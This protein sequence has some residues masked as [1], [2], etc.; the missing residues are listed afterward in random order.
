[1]GVGFYKFSK[2]EAER[3]AQQRQ[4]EQLRIEASVITS[5]KISCV[6]NHEMMTIML[7]RLNKNV[8][9]INRSRRNT[10]KNWQ[11]VQK[12]YVA[13][14]PG[15]RARWRQTSKYQWILLQRMLSTILFLVFEIQ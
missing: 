5:K 11:P 15:D 1:M 8:L 9:Y 6:T 12:H 7:S 2:D 13:K 4:L 14:E 10:K 3:E